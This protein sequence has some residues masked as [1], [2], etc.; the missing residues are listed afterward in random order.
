MSVDGRYRTVAPPAPR[1]IWTVAWA[2]LASQLVF[3]LD[4]GIRPSDGASLALSAAL[5]GVVVGFVS[6]GVV[7]ART[8]R[9]VLAWAILV[10][11]LVA[12][13]VLLAR[14]D[15]LRH[16]SLTGLSLAFTAVALGALARFRR[17]DWYAWQRA[18][19]TAA[20]RSSIRRLL[21]IGVLV[22]AL[23]GVA[24]MPEEPALIQ[25]NLGDG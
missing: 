16:G 6:A 8:V 4:H 13:L 17:T 24:E 25:V 20:R 14:A 1:S 2:M 18:Y 12:D 11:T 21:V 15:D 3:V 23:G 10:L 9:L 7:R 5:G 22:G 19:P